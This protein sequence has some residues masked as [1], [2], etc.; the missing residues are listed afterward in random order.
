MIKENDVEYVD[1]RFTDPRGKWQ[2]VTQHVDPIDE[3][4]LTEG[5]MFDGS[6]IAG[7]KAINESDMTLMPDLSSAVMDPFS[8]AELALFCDIMEPE[9]RRA[10]TVTRAAPQSA[11][12]YLESSPASATPPSSARKPNSSSSTTF[13]RRVDEPRFYEVDDIEGPYNTG[14][15]YR[16]KAIWPPSGVKGGYFPVPPVDSMTDIAP[17]CSRSWPWACAVEKHHHEVAPVSTSLA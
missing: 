2:H 6:S 1:F 14:A 11:L 13:V 10:Y 5:I 12:A 7:W 17:K 15:D 16:R 9:H 8:P 3:D 4:L